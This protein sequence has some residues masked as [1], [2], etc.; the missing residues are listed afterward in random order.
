MIHATRL[1][2]A[3]AIRN[4]LTVATLAAAP[5]NLH[6]QQAVPK[7][8]VG[9]AKVD[10]H[11]VAYPKT[12]RSTSAVKRAPVGGSERVAPTPRTAVAP[13]VTIKEKPTAKTPR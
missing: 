5:A 4:L 12:K 13:K 10:S 6:A 2:V 9:L 8:A 11:V 3:R 1:P 7:S